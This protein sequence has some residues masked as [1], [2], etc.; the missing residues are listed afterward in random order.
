[1]INS[2]EEK[3][4]TEFKKLNNDNIATIANENENGKQLVLCL[5]YITKE[6][7]EIINNQKVFFYQATAQGEYEQ[8][9]PNNESTARLNA[10]AITDKKGRIFVKTVLP[11]DYG[12]TDDN[13]HIH[14]TVSGAKPEAY[15]IHF[16]QYANNNLQNFIKN[17]D[18]HFLANLKYTKDSILVAFMTIEPKN[19]KE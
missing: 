5:T 12:N 8:I 7:K 9:D 10:F 6:T 13:R 3:I 11:G 15:D 19:I 1:M 2:D 17:S 16:R 4:L 18:Q 14:S